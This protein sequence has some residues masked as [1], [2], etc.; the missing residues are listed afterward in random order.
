M[1]NGPNPGAR[2][3]RRQKGIA[4]TVFVLVERESDLAYVLRPPASLPGATE[5]IVAKYATT[6]SAK[7]G[8]NI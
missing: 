1:L 2:R 6:I 7:E 3:A 8:A 4:G 5:E